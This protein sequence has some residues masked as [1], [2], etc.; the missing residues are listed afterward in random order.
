MWYVRCGAYTIFSG[1]STPERTITELEKDAPSNPYTVTLPTSRSTTAT[2]GK[3]PEAV[4]G[5]PKNA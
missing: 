2:A 1:V 5:T 3:L 4:Q